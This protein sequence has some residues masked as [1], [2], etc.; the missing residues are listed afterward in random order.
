MLCGQFVFSPNK[1]LCL[2]SGIT[3]YFLRSEI[4]NRYVHDSNE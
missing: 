2:M 3:T 4:L 1:G